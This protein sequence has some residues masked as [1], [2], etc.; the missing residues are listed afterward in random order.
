MQAAAVAV[1]DGGEQGGFDV[2]EG[3]PVVRQ[4]VDVAVGDAAVEVRFQIL[5]V[6]AVG[7]SDV[8]RDVEVA[9]VGDDFGKR[10][11]AAVMRDF[12]LRVEGVGDFVDVLM[13]QA[14]F[15]AVFDV[16]AA[17]VNH[18]YGAAVGEV[19]LVVIGGGDGARFVDDDDAG[20]DAGA[21]K[22]VGGQP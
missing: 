8:A 10:H 12:F 11:E 19:A 13:A 20:G 14:V 7:R 17:R 16:A 15:V 4:R 3:V 22:E 5:R 6:A 1:C 21:V 2:G 18:K 9:V